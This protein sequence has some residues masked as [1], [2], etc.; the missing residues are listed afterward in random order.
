VPDA[1]GHTLN[2]L[3]Q[4]DIALHAPV[5]RYPGSSQANMLQRVKEHFHFQ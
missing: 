4:P 2:V 5:M 3:H 1:C